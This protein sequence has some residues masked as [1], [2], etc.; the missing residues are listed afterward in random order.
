MEV[1]ALMQAP[2]SPDPDTRFAFVAVAIILQTL[3]GA[4]ALL[5]EAAAV[6][7]LTDA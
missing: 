7:W 2:D 6:E 1:H 5:A 4:A 3:G